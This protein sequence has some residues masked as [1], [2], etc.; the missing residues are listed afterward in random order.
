[1]LVLKVL[2]YDVPDAD[3][4]SPRLQLETL[5]DARKINENISLKDDRDDEI[6]IK[7]VL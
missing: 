2:V 6:I 5:S 3:G 7:Y 1:M 4:K